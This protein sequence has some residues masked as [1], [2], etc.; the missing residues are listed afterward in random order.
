MMSS[1]PKTD[2]PCAAGDGN[3]REVEVRDGAMTVGP[4]CLGKCCDCKSGDGKTVTMTVKLAVINEVISEDGLFLAGGTFGNPGKAEQRFAD[5]GQGVDESAH[6]GIY[7]LQLTVPA[8][9]HHYYTFTNGANSDYSGKE[10]IQ[11]KPCAFGTFSD[12]YIAN[13]GEKDFTVEHC[14]G[15]CARCAPKETSDA[16]IDMTFEVDMSRETVSEDGVYLAGGRFG[17]PGK[18]D[19]FKMAKKAGAVYTITV[20]VPAGTLLCGSILLLFEL[21]RFLYHIYITLITYLCQTR[22]WTGLCRRIV[23]L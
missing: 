9:S 2:Q 3:E 16:V 22:P 20:P 11:G 6:D 13:T 15:H 8:N 18:N 14:F 1:L 7:T 21:R 19:A 12:R 4:F 17:K 10:N 23:Q 5:D